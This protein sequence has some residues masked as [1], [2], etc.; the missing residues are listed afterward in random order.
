MKR[1]NIKRTVNL[2][3]AKILCVMSILLLSALYILQINKEVSQRYLADDCEKKISRF[4]RENNNLEK[5]LAQTL[6]LNK[7]SEVVRT[8]GYLKSDRVQ[9][10][11]VMDNRV[12]A[13]YQANEKMAD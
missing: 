10:I 13:N 7:V 8:L 1:R 12:V 11:R 3:N 9:Y 4:A 5:D 6:S 2:R